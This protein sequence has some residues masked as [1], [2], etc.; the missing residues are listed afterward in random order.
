M[1]SESDGHLNYEHFD[2]S[3]INVALIVK[4][5]GHVE[6]FDKFVLMFKVI[7]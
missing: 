6:N 2:G 3:L 5:L 4:N 1:T 7:F